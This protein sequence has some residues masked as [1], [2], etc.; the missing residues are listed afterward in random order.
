MPTSCDSVSIPTLLIISFFIEP[1]TGRDRRVKFKSATFDNFERPVLAR[2]SH[3]EK[4][5]FEGAIVYS[6]RCKK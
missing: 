2:D 6:Y 4:E 3:G 5:Y 1:S